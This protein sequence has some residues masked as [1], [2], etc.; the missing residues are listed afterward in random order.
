MEICEAVTEARPASD[1]VSFRTVA[2]VS[3]AACIRYQGPYS[4]L[5]ESYN[6]LFSWIEARPL[7]REES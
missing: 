2:G 5:G 6:E 4:S 1:T 3:E 7:R